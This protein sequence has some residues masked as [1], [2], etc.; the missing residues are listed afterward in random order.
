MLV[1]LFVREQFLPL[2][3][4][5]RIS[6]FS[7]LQAL[8]SDQV[9]SHDETTGDFQP[10]NTD[11]NNL[12]AGGKPR[13]TAIFGDQRRHGRPAGLPGERAGADCPSCLGTLAF[14]FHSPVDGNGRMARFLMSVMMASGGDPWTTMR[15]NRRKACLDALE[16][17]SAGA[18]HFAV[19]QFHPRGDEH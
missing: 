19:R 11:D 17:A 12:I 15:T 3:G 18:E 14:W 7:A 16:A 2:H 4:G 10:E 6:G 13:A 8:A 5:P 9:G 1:L